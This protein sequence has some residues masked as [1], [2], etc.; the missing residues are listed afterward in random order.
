MI[1]RLEPERH[2]GE[3]VGTGERDAHFPARERP[4]LGSAGARNTTAEPSS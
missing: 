3:G 4:A 2:R 1:T